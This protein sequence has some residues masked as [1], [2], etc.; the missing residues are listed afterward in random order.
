MM[1][2]RAFSA[3]LLVAVCAVAGPLA[4]APTTVTVD[5]VASVMQGRADVARDIALE[6]ALRRAVEQVI[7][8][9]VE[10]ETLVQNFQLI[11]DKIY[12]QTKGYVTNYQV[13][14]ERRDGELFR[15]TVKAAVDAGHL[16][17]DLQ[18]LGLLYRR[19]NKPRVMIIVAE[20]HAG[21]GTS[22]RP[23]NPRSSGSWLKRASKWWIR[24]RCGPSARA[25]R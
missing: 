13:V 17:A 24:H 1:L 23:A 18:A 15:V 10:S 12:T 6:D 7:G 16:Q 21:A 5:G 9:M 3:L 2:P 25:I 8:T 19:M 11:S 14:S 22:D 20:R 4:A